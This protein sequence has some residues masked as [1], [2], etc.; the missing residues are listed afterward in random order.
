[1]CGRDRAGVDRQ[2][3]VRCRHHGAGTFQHRHGLETRSQC[4]GTGRPVCLDIGHRHPQKTRRLQRMRRE[5]AAGCL[6]RLGQQPQRIG[7]DH[8][9]R[10]AGQR[11][12]QPLSCSLILP[13]AATHHQDGRRPRQ[14]N[15]CIPHK[16]HD[17]RVKRVHRLPSLAGCV[18]RGVRFVVGLVF[19]RC[20]RCVLVRS[21]CVFRRRLHILGIVFWPQRP[22]ILGRTCLQ[23]SLCLDGNP[24]PPG[25]GA[26]CAL[27]SQPCRTGHA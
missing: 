12:F 5:D 4:P 8:Q 25:T 19:R 21:T 20:S 13:Q 14:G 10:L 27:R 26:R 16:A 18:L 1:M 11:T 6:R 7:I 24:D 17:F 22:G 9:R 3:T 2:A 15:I 23:G